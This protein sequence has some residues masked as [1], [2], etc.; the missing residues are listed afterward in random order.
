M[1]AVSTVKEILRLG[2]TGGL[3][4]D[5]IDLQAAKL[6]LLTDEL[7]L[8]HKRESQLE[9]EVKQLRLLAQ[10][11]QPITGGFHEFC[12]ALWKRTEK[13]FEPFPYCKECASHS[14]MTGQPPG[15]SP[16]FWRCPNG[17]NAPYGGTP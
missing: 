8:S 7:A 1:N 14:V 4:K 9:L 13:G 15:M 3:S 10:N 16:M 5:V 6:R 11:N 2:T 17:H 12:G